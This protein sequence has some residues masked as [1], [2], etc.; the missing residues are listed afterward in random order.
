MK[1]SIIVIALV[2]KGLSCPSL[3]GS[4]ARDDRAGPCSSS[5]IPDSNCNRGLNIKK[6]KPYHPNTSKLSTLPKQYLPGRT[7][8]FQDSWFSA[9]SWLH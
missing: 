3:C 5:E 1:L 7:L 2:Q 4:D 9:F 6:E 8:A